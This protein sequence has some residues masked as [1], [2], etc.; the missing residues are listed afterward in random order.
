[1]EK[2]IYTVTYQVPTANGNL[3]DTVIHTCTDLADY[4]RYIRLGEAGKVKIIS[5]SRK[6]K[7]A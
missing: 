4:Y 6:L 5:V 1:M 3:S 2:D 7:S